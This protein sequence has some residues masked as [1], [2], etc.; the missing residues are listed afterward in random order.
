MCWA[1]RYN[2][3]SILYS[4]LIGN[5]NDQIYFL[6]R[7]ENSVTSKLKQGCW[8]LHYGYDACDSIVYQM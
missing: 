2:P 8:F 1:T 7:N 5:F 6:N 3:L 4:I